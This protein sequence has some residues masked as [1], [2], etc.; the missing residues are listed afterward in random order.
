MP[1]PTSPSDRPN[2]DRRPQGCGRIVV[3]DSDGV[4][5]GAWRLAPG[6]TPALVLVDRLCRLQ[7]VA[8]RRGWSIVLHDPAVD[9]ADVLDFLGLAEVLLGV[10]SGVEALGDAE[11]AEQLGVEEVVEPDD[12]AP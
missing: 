8:H 9:L 5:R 6:A 11:E 12:L 4:E 10:G 2:D 3:T 1:R 7:L